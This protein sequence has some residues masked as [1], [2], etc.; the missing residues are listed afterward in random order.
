MA[1]VHHHLLFQAR[2]KIKPG[3]LGED[4]FRKFM[5]NL[6]KALPTS[7]TIVM[8]DFNATTDSVVIRRMCENLVDTDPATTPTWCVYPEG[9]LTCNRANIDTR[10]DYIFTSRDIKTASFQV[11][12][13]KGSDHLPIT[14]TITT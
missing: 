8:G 14:V 3:S 6:L 10:L 1:I 9:C 4:D 12:N 7:R 2:V 13:S 11:G 5:E